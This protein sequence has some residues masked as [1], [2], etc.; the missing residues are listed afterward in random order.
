MFGFVLHLTPLGRSIFAIGATRRL[1]ST[2]AYG[3]SASSTP[4][5]SGFIGALAGVLLTFELS[6]AEPNNG[7]GLRVVGGRDRAPGRGLDLRR[8][9]SLI[10]VVLAVLSSPAY[11]RRS[12]DEHP[13]AQ[14]QVLGRRRS[15]AA[16]RDRAE[17][18]RDREAAATANAPACPRPGPGWR[19]GPCR[20][21][22]PPPS[23]PIT[24]PHPIN[25]ARP[26]ETEGN[27]PP[28]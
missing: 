14:V 15:P 6:T 4:V 8:K 28:W 13:L 10:G 18:G 26:T 11:K 22:S 21:L 2:P 19:P 12:P 17:L 1:R 25:T 23:H 5:R 9:G 24:P 7:N 3:S 20:A 27:T 16:Q